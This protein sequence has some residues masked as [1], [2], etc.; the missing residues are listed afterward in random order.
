MTKMT[1]LNTT[2]NLEN[3]IDTDLKHL[4]TGNRPPNR[5][6]LEQFLH[7]QAYFVA[8][9]GPP[10]VWRDACVG[11]WLATSV[12]E[13]RRQVVVGGARDDAG[14][15]PAWMKERPKL[16]I[17]PPWSFV[18]FQFPPQFGRYQARFWP[19]GGDQKA[20]C[21]AGRGH[22]WGRTGIQPEHL[23]GL[24]WTIFSSTTLRRWQQQTQNQLFHQEQQYLHVFFSSLLQ[25]APDI[26]FL[27][28]LVA[29]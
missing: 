23:M 5:W 25:F 3:P 26:G 14:W 1:L 13:Q 22:S 4:K 15:C 12:F 28:A 18:L 20:G 9:C 19:H 11:L 24:P 21:S 8:I 27:C 10:G 17:C 7:S 2:W 29:C 16:E 6:T